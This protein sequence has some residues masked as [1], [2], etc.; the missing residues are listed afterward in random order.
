MTIYILLPAYNEAANI[1]GLLDG[2]EREHAAWKKRRGD[3]PTPDYR[4]VVIDDGS[5]DGTADEIRAAHAQDSITLVQHEHNRGLAAALNT[6]LYTILDQA[7][8]EDIVVTLDADGTHPPVTIFHLVNRIADGFDIV[9]ASRYAPGGVERGVSLIRRILSRGAKVA[10]HLFLPHIPLRDFSCG[11]RAMKAKLLRK[12]LNQWGDRLFETPG[13]TCTGELMLK[14]AA[15]TRREA[16][17][18]IPFELQYDLKG[19]ES[20]MPAMKTILGTLT[21]IWRA[22]SWGRPE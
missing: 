2:I 17:T 19:G 6:G 21:L 14:A 20:K 7:R 4:P 16:I 18:E 13:F 22:R 8:D 10:Y 1:R 15:H 11:F 3:S 12:T 9:V 5:S